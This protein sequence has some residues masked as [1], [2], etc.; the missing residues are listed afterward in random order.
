MNK[1]LRTP[2][3]LLLLLF[4]LSATPA[5]GQAIPDHIPDVPGESLA[6]R[7]RD[8]MAERHHATLSRFFTAGGFDMAPVTGNGAAYQA[9][10]K[11]GMDF[12]SGDAVFVFFS[13]RRLPVDRD[14]I[15]PLNGVAFQYYYGMGYRVGGQ[16]FLG[17]S[18]FAQRTGLNVGLGVVTS[19]VSIVAIDIE[20]TYALLSGDSWTVPVGVKL[21]LVAADSQ[22][23]AMSSAFLGLS[24]GV[25]WRL[26]D[27]KRLD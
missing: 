8:R 24:V 6:D 1:L 23:A 26:W 3:A 7:E 4:V 12:R 15:S 14:P 22:D 27:R 21:G 18:Q 9:N 10:G 16:R 19:D 13:S 20:P 11:F 5:V 25:Q 17:E 2:A